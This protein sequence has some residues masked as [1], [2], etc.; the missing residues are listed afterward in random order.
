MA[1]RARVSPQISADRTRT[2]SAV[3]ASAM[4]PITLNGSRAKPPS[5]LQ[6]MKR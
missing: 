5:P 6:E 2:T 1:L 3:E 4:I